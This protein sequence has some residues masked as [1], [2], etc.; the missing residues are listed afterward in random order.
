MGSSMIFIHRFLEEV[1]SFLTLVH[2]NVATGLA[3]TH[4]KFFV[5]L[6]VASLL[7]DIS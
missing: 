3:L 2:K 6:Q 5:T 7:K 1:D 4:R